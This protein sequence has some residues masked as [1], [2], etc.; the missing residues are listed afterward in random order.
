LGRL[1]AL[2][3][4]TVLLYQTPPSA[5]NIPSVTIENKSGARMIVE[6]LIQVHQRRRIVFL[7]GP[8]GNEDSQWRERGYR[9]ALEAN[10]IPFDPSLVTVGGFN[11]DEARVAMQELLIEGVE[12]DAVFGGDDDTAAGVISAL[13]LAEIEIPQ[14]VAVVGFDDVPIARYL[15]PALTTVRVPTEQVGREGVRQLVS[16]IRGQQ[17]EPLVLMRIE[18]VI[19]ESCGCTP[20]QSP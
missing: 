5:L 8:E 11:E 7:R 13:S 1:Y 12:F 14:D 20:A 3:F 9:E 10:G 15:R 19:R 16:L 17:A 2:N 18:L 6:H 4:P